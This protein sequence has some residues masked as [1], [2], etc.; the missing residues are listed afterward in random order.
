MVFAELVGADAPAGDALV[1][2][3]L[4]AALEDA[5]PIDA[6]RL[7]FWRC[8]LHAPDFRAMPLPAGLGPLAALGGCSPAERAVW[9]LEKLS[10]L[11]LPAMASALGMPV[12]WVQGHLVAAEARIGAAAPACQEA[13]A[14]RQASL[15]RA[16][17]AA[18]AAAL[19]VHPV[20]MTAPVPSHPP[21]ARWGRPAA[22]AVVVLVAAGLLWTFRGRQNDFDA[23]KIRTRPLAETGTPR[24]YTATEALAL[25][26]D[27]ALL[28]LPPEDAAIARDAA[29]LSWYAAELARDAGAYTPPPAY[30]APEQAASSDEHADAP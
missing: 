8:L 10:G 29:F 23:P 14:N 30:E 17:L 4:R 1:A 18:V 13:L 3:C 19:T 20:S 16:R 7:G 5:G 15:P 25:H 24:R 27:R 9:L 28:A 22:F 11:D 12:A 21:V 2:R 26:P 6:A